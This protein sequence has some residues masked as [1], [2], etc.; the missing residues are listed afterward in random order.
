MQMVIRNQTRGSVGWSCVAHLSFCFKKTLY[1]AFHRCF[2]PNVGS[3]GYSV[4]EEIFF[5]NNQGKNC[6]WW[7]CLLTDRD[8]MSNHYRGLSIDASYQGL[9]H[10][11]KR[12]QR[13]I[14]FRNRPIRNKNCLWLPCLL[15]DR[16]KM[17]N[18]YRGPSID[19]SYQVSVYLAKRFQRR[20]LK[21]MI[22]QKQELSVA[23]IFVNE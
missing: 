7:P 14:C 6:L 13:R 4:S 11:V 8:E 10:L 18:I 2:L 17:C 16:D 5:R 15:T 9:V 12:F 23:A 20:R 1:R 21:K 22:N 19:A 3:F